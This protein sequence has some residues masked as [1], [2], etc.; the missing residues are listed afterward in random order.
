M[1]RSRTLNATAYSHFISA[2]VRGP[3]TRP[4]LMRITGMGQ[5]LVSRLVKALRARGTVP[6]RP[7]YNEVLHISGWQLDA[8][9][10]PT[11][12]E[13]SLG[14]GKDAVQPIKPRIQVVR[15]YLQ[16][17]KQRKAKESET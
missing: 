13:F 2:L 12:A 9:G 3:Q 10:Y 14:P 4:E 17:R 6:G 7:D 15:D 11:L 1:S 5:P 16:R 8:R